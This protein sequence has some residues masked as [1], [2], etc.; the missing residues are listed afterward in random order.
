MAAY[1]ANNILKKQAEDWLHNRLRKLASSITMKNHE[2]FLLISNHV[3]DC[4]CRNTPRTR[5]LEMLLDANSKPYLREN[6]GPSAKAYSF[7]VY[8]LDQNPSTPE[9]QRK[10]SL[11]VDFQCFANESAPDR[12]NVPIVLTAIR[13]NCPFARP[14]HNQ[15]A[16]KRNPRAPPCEARQRK[17]R[18]RNFGSQS[19]HKK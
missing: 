19:N 12:P 18:P 17:N 9:N 10:I 6:N 3:E 11:P 4:P 14:G 16:C 2:E 15:N 13:E 1:G 5:V 7:I 8:L